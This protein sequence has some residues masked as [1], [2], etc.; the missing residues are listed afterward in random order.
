MLGTYGKQHK[1]EFML[2][3]FRKE[4]YD[5]NFM[6]CVSKEELL[7]KLVGR[8]F[9]ISYLLSETIKCEVCK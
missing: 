2:V 3:N 6:N 7:R 4:K 1:A 9:S 8:K 5:N